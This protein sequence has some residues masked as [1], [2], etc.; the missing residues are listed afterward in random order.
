M[1]F[2]RG[3]RYYEAHSRTVKQRNPSLLIAAVV[4]HKIG[5][6]RIMQYTNKIEGHPEKTIKTVH[7]LLEFRRKLP[8]AWDL[9]LAETFNIYEIEAFSITK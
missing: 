6:R 3:S 8:P 7:F 5:N 9:P 2:D 1:H 4:P